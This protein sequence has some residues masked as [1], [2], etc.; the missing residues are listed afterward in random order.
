M[1]ATIIDMS[2]TRN[3]QRLADILIKAKLVDEMQV[4]SA[5]PHLGLWGKHLPRVLA[6]TGFVDEDELTQ[7]I[8]RALGMPLVHLA[9][10]P[11]DLHALAKLDVAFC[12][13]HAVFPVALKGNALTVAMVDPT[14]V[15]TLEAVQARAGSRVRPVLASEIEIENSI[16]RHYRGLDPKARREVHKMTEEEPL[17]VSM[18]RSLEPK[19]E[20]AEQILKSSGVGF[21]RE[22][23]ERLEAAKTNQQKA[24]V[25]LRAVRQLLQEKGLLQR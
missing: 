19:R 5:A 17:E 12:E 14:D 9:M 21:S 1:Q 4:K 20:G 10:Q 6:E 8:A 7:A 22:E 25:I 11:K 3:E 13:A 2:L 24:S 18:A 16:L 15:G 23:L